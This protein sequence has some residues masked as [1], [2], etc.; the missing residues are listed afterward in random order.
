VR[1]VITA[2]LIAATVVAFGVGFALLF[3]GRLL[4][5]LAQFNR[6]AMG[7]FEA[8]GRW[9]GVALLCLACFTAVAASGLL[10]GRKWGWWMAVGLFVVNGCGDVV[11][12]A[13]TRDAW[14]SGSGIA[15]CSAFLYALLRMRR[16]FN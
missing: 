15:I 13:V 10:R 4:E 1:S 16:S 9:S 3:P 12:Y 8:L 2:F 7:G 6:P 11:G 5:W 14:R